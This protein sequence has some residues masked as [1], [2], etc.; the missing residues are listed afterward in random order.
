MRQ[1]LTT[2]TAERYV[3]APP[4]VVYDILADVTRTPERTPDVVRCEWIRGATGPA[5]G[6]WFKSL[7]TV[8]YGPKWPNR[9]VVI[10]ADPGREFSFARH[11]VAGGVVE[12]RHRLVPEGDGTRVVESYEVT[13]PI[14]IVGWFIIGVLMRRK[15][16]RADLRESM[17]K[18]LG[19]L[20]ELA[21]RS[22]S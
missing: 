21:E 22:R 14:P 13:K 7:N 11:E 10:A 20:A 9:S 5:V 8:G 15:D 2:D 18:S 12:W 19:R 3:D 1:E 4:E 6:A 17:A 16:R